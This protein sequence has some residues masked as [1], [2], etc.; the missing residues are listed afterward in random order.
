MDT[1]MKRTNGTTAMP[2]MTFGGM[3]DKIFQNNLHRFL[4]DGFWGFNG[5]SHNTGIPVNMK[6]TEKSYE[7]ELVAP[8]LKKE[9]FRLSIN[10]DLLTINCHQ[11]HEQNQQ[12]ADGNW[13]RREYHKHTFTQNFSL[14]ESVDRNNI[15]ARYSDGVLYITLPKKADAQHLT[16]TIEVK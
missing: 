5:L 8:G 10:G 14:D 6:E 2:A 1:L 4:D 7:V 9:N 15:A 3:V 16:H 12:P 13:I 11:E